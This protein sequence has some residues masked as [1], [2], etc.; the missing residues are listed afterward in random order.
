LALSVLYTFFRQES[1]VQNKMGGAF[2][3]IEQLTDKLNQLLERL[4]E[5]LPKAERIALVDDI[6]E[7]L[8]VMFS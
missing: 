6:Q 7:I 5:D 1:V 8:S 2:M 3:N 4:K